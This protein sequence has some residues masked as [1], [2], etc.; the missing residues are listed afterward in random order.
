[1]RFLLSLIMTCRF[2]PLPILKILLN[3]M[4]LNR[5]FV[6]YSDTQEPLIE[7]MKYL[8]ELKKAIN[9]EIFDS[10]MREYQVRPS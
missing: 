1:M 2:T 10:W 4:N 8:R 9:C 5:W 7:C 3:Y 6:I